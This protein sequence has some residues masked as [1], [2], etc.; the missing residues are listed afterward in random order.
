QALTGDV[1]LQTQDYF[2]P[3]VWQ[4]L[5]LSSA[6]AETE[7]YVQNSS[8][9]AGG[10]LTATATA[11]QTITATV[12]AA[13]AAIAG[14]A[15]GGVGLSGA[16][17]NSTNKISMQVDAFIDGNGA[18]GVQAADIALTSH[19][20]SLIK[21]VTVGASL[22]GAF[23]GNGGVAISI[24]V[25]L[26]T[27][28]IDNQVE[29]LIENAPKVVSM[30]T[31]TLD[32]QEQSGIHAVAV[33]ASVGVGLSG[34]TGVAVSGAGANATNVILTK[35]NALIQNSSVTS[36][37]NVDIT[38][39][40]S[41][42]IP[43]ASL[44]VPSTYT[45]LTKTTAA[46][47]STPGGSAFAADLDYA[48]QTHSLLNNETDTVS[49]QSQ[50]FSAGTPDPDVVFLTKL[51]SMLAGAGFTLSTNPLDLAV[52]IRKAGT[53]WSVT[54]RSSG[55]TLT[56]VNSNGTFSVMEPEISAT[57]IGASLAVG[58]GGSVGAGVAIG[59]ALA[60]NLIGYDQDG[61]KIPAQVQA[62]IN[63]SSVNAGTG[64]LNLTATAS[65]SIDALV[66][67]FAAAVG[68]SGGIG[69]A[70][71]GAG[72]N[73]LNEMA[74]LI[75]ADIDGDGSSGIQ[76][77]S[78]TLR[79][80]DS[81]SIKA[82]T[83]AASLAVSFGSGAVS[84]AVGAAIANNEIGNDV[85]AYLT[86]AN[87]VAT[88]AL[89]ATAAEAASIDATTFAA[90]AAIALSET[91]LGVA[92]GVLTAANT[93]TNTI[94]AYISGSTPIQASAV[95]LSASDEGVIQSYSFSLALAAGVAGVAVGVGVGNNSINDNVSAYVDDSTITATG[96]I[97]VTA[98]SK[99]TI[100][101]TSTVAAIS[102]SIGAAVAVFSATT[103]IGGTTQAYLQDAALS[104]TGQVI[105]VTATSS[106]NL[107]PTVTGGAGGVVG[108]AVMVSTATVNGSTLASLQGQ[109]IVSAGSLTVTAND[110]STA[111]PVTNVGGVGG[112]SVNDAS[113]TT[114][115]G[116]Q[117]EA[118]I[119]ANALITML[120]GSLA[121]A[122]VSTASA[123]T[124]SESGGG[125]VIAV[126]NI[127]I[128][129]TINSVT[130]ATVAAGAQLQ[131]ASGNV[132]ITANSAN[133]ANAT[134]ENIGG[135]GVNVQVS[136][137]TAN[138]T[139]TT[140]ALM[141]GNL[142]ASGLLIESTADDQ[143]VAGAGSYGGGVVQ[144]GVANVNATTSPTV[145]AQI[146]GTVQVTN[147][148][149]VDAIATSNANT[150]NNSG[151][152]GVVNVSAQNATV[153]LNPN[154]S[155]DVAADA[156]LNAGGT[157]TV[158]AQHGLGTVLTGVTSAGSS[159]ITGLTS[160]SNLAVGMTVTGTDLT[161]GPYT[162]AS[163][164][165]ATSI[166]LNKGTGVTS[167]SNASLTF[168]TPVLSNGTFNAATAV[169]TTN[170]TISLVGNSGL[171][172]GDTVTYL[173]GSGN[174]AVGGLTNS[175]QYNVIADPAKPNVLSF[176]A[177][178]GTPT[179]LTGVTTAGSDVITG[180]AS[181][182][183]LAVG[184]TVTGTN[185][186]GGPYVIASILSPTSI[187]LNTGTGVTAAASA[188]LSFSTLSVNTST[189]TIHFAAPDNFQS[190]D[191][192]VYE[193]PAGGTPVGGLVNGNTYIVN[194][195]DPQTITLVKPANWPLPAPI[196][197]TGTSVSNSKLTIAN[198][199][200]TVG[201]AVIY[202]APAAASA[203]GLSQVDGANNTINVGSNNDLAAGDQ[204]IYTTPSQTFTSAN[205]NGSE[206]IIPGHGFT[207]G[208][209]LQYQPTGSA[210][211]ELANGQNLPAGIYYA[212]RVDSNTLEL[213]ATLADATA[214]VSHAMIFAAQTGASGTLTAA[215]LAGL[216]SGT[217]YYVLVPNAGSPDQIQLSLKANGSAL[218]LQPST[219]GTDA[220]VSN[221]LRNVADQPIGGL[222]DGATYY[223]ANVNGNAFQL[224]TDAA[225][226]HIVTLTSYA[227]GDATM[228]TLTGTSTI[229]A[230]G[231]LP[232]SQGTGTQT[233]V[234]KLTSSGT[235]TQTLEGVGGAAALA[236]TTGSGVSIASASG[237][238][239]G[240]V[241]VASVTSTVT[242]TPTVSTTVEEGVHM[243]AAN[244]DIESNA[245]G[246]VASVATGAGGGLV[247]VG[248]SNSNVNVTP[249][250]TLLISSNAVLDATGNITV[251]ST[252]STNAQAQGTSD[253]G[254][255]VAVGA[256]NVTTT[257]SHSATVEIGVSARLAAQGT[258]DV[259]SFS[260]DTAS[261]TSSVAEGGIVATA[262]NTTTLNV[263]S[264][265]TP[266]TTTT[267]IDSGALLEGNTVTVGATVNSLNLTDTASESAGGVGA[268]A[269][270]NAEMTIYDNTE[271]NL[272]GN[273][274]VTGD[275]VTIN[276]V[277][278]NVSLNSQA[279]ANIY[280]LIG[281]PASDAKI[282]YE[283]MAEVNA[284]SG[285]HVSGGT[286]N[287]NATQQITSYQRT[288]NAYY[289]GGRNGPTSNTDGALNAQREIDWN[290][291]ISALSL[292][293]PVLV[294]SADGTIAK[295]VDITV[296]NGKTQGTLI[297]SSTLSVDPISDS[298][299]QSNAV[300]FTANKVA[301]M[302][303]ETAPQGVITG[304]GGTLSDAVAFNTVTI[305]NY[306]NKA[307]A[308][309]GIQTV[310][311][312]AHPTIDLNADSTSGFTFAV[313][314]TVG[315]TDVTI[316][317]EGTGN[318]VLNAPSVVPG[319]SLG[320]SIYNPVGTTT[321]IAKNGS[322]LNG[323][324]PTNVPTIWTRTLDVTASGSVGASTSRLSVDLVLPYAQTDLNITA[325]GNVYL[326]LSGV[327]RETLTDPSFLGG[328]IQTSGLID[329]LVE[330]IVEDVAAL[331]AGSV[332]AYRVDNGGT[333]TKVSSSASPDPH[334]F[335][336]YTQSTL[337]AG[338][339]QFDR[340]VAGGNITIN[341]S[342]QS[343]TVPA[344]GFTSKT[345]TPGQ[346]Y[347]HISG[348]ITLTETT[349]NF[350]I[351]RVASDSGD[352][353][354][355]AENGSILAAV[356]NPLLAGTPPWVYGNN[357]T[358][359]A[360]DGSIG[361]L[362]NF[363]Q[364]VSTGALTALAELGVYL[365]GS[366]GNLNVNEVLSR[367]SDVALIA[368]DGS[369]RNAA[370]LG[371]QFKHP[372]TT[373]IQ[374]QNI[375]LLATSAGSTIGSSTYPLEI[376]GAG[377]GQQ[378]NDGFQID[379]Y[380]PG[381]GNLVAQ[382][383]RDVDL[384]ETSG[385]L[386][387][388]SVQSASGNVSLTVHD[389]VLTGQDLNLL[390][391]GGTTL[392]GV[393]IAAAQISA[394][395]GS[396]SV[397]AGDNVTVPAGTSITAGTGIVVEG[398]YS[399]SNGT[400]SYDNDY[401]S[402]PNYPNA[403]GAIIAITGN[404]QAPTVNIKSGSQT[405][406]DYIELLNPA[407]I[408]ATPAGTTP[409]WTTTITGGGGDDRIF[410]DAV[411]GP[412]TVAE[413]SGAER[414]YVASNAS[415][416]LFTVG[417]SATSSQL[418]QLT[419]TP[420]AG[421]V[422][423][424][425]LSGVAA[426][427]ATTFNASSVTGNLAANTINVGANS[428]LSAGT[429]V[430]YTTPSQTFTPADVNSD[431]TTIALAGHGFA[432]GEALLYQAATPLSLAAGGSLQSGA[433]YYAIQVNANTFELADSYADAIAGNP[434]QFTSPATGSNNQKLTA[435]PVGGLT[436][437][438]T[439]FVLVPDS[440]H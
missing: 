314:N 354:L 352:V 53:E 278:N 364:I 252:T 369:I 117:T 357:V 185:L 150:T 420:A 323:S 234:L 35:T 102:A 143:S 180:L 138:D 433:I 409:A 156:S 422:Y 76:A 317:N 347:A 244:V 10:D 391:S 157:I 136:S 14:G 253:G 24:G 133:N 18:T 301:A 177:T 169:S 250:S 151:T 202:H 275:T 414:I 126:T 23:G 85:A 249:T 417:S 192:V 59:A 49:G 377:T 135:G 107:T 379:T 410:I 402:S 137:P 280:T 84:V 41:S 119:P 196:N 304:T 61:N 294:V 285:A 70:G 230:E 60:Q 263:G 262:T 345:S 91:S 66:G 139:S 100:T 393:A 155:S 206:I 200:F 238:G 246:D 99:P 286:V 401:S 21:A 111:A 37:G 224:A 254:G 310:N 62:Q 211:L 33:A 371:S 174:T 222:S 406:V 356:N 273:S 307:I 427:N 271:V 428:G 42:A 319:T 165:S 90:A 83:G 163:I 191:E 359:T 195:I 44:S 5:N 56:I 68:G 75:T 116:R 394:P 343:S 104:A 276:S 298:E 93:L 115:L 269:T 407:G 152:G 337:V 172:T 145:E 291:N 212:I 289:D 127:G 67:A 374:G 98:T 92:A 419:G 334:V 134:S 366:S 109:T 281:Y 240:A 63:N 270:A 328:T 228:T 184:A 370:V 81:S 198:N 190:G 52:T 279:T 415:R 182:S 348:D 306:S 423:Q 436:S 387:V 204:V 368:Q 7:A 141:L 283:S 225:G 45:S 50:T 243:N 386:N 392:Q 318:V 229:G 350:N 142:S 215:P 396:V 411:A 31:I 114:T 227:T 351:A 43:P 429:Q 405:N 13:S 293:S 378:P 186:T 247:Q 213:A 308:I 38:A 218:S 149:G 340:L 341:E 168:A 235:G 233:L 416:A 216:T 178:F 146:G 344:I 77:G 292:P 58:A 360:L 197:F 267:S 361:L 261:A 295:A 221:T 398:D 30:G 320:Y 326:D 201:E 193:A 73:A 19:D 11:S 171:Q 187:A 189:G 288:S 432:T 241:Q 122:A 2:D 256:A 170:N 89:S 48:G 214:T 440:T 300:T 132:A 329:L 29:A 128:T 435:V 272:A 437:G 316:D 40:A 96:A 179:V 232:T 25:S 226:T 72:S 140:K 430:T 1:N 331:P 103:T 342:S 15:K 108:V 335:P 130:S 210:P 363:L 188:S 121:V 268:G 162:I 123:N 65:E 395:L 236:N 87:N 257:I 144:V 173:Q 78:I 105:Q 223:V 327:L 362:S 349:G 431:N 112:I 299:N 305:T 384:M 339:Y 194:V 74:T 242:G 88:G 424:L 248:V 260:N 32:A 110:S 94:D 175:R 355:A 129:S 3:S 153:N 118:S 20:T 365:T 385:A 296:N 324:S 176:G 106:E 64:G 332:Y 239:G 34:K 161:G 382:A 418:L 389:S 205:V 16:G 255:L 333:P 397:Y 209:T 125:G 167:D 372:L 237:G 297:G 325:G 79:A 439:Y 120:A 438:S 353:A 17:A 97:N 303:G 388:L 258:L 199:G 39:N 9:A 404:L 207:T 266:A 231:I 287:V 309:N 26:A 259:E 265:S 434:L 131:V 8:I 284:A 47:A 322:V 358:F 124:S 346:I 425:T 166:T 383:D 28:E 274:T 181:T 27:D 315:P 313:D 86:D 381:T 376:L 413:S 4:Q 80:T 302:N 46:G 36:H 282:D 101:T 6:P 321:I 220:S 408:N 380:A 400:P 311:P 154:V 367:L 219:A 277:L 245:M 12:V 390:P 160:T 208:E 336:D 113:S 147:N 183:S 69:V 426:A 95:T 403:T 51:Q 399:Q 290:G 217:A 158:D 338:T 412:T 71:A 57:V 82:V 330:P 203:F 54:D 264:S 251:K 375:D 164:P 312:N 22:A 148:I 159:T 55:I 373:N 421:E